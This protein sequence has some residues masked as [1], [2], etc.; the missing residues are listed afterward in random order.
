MSKCV[1]F[2]S[3]DPGAPELYWNNGG[4]Y[5][6]LEQLSG[7]YTPGG[8]NSTTWGKPSTA[9]LVP[10]QFRENY[11]SPSHE[12]IFFGQSFD[13]YGAAGSHYCF[14][15]EMADDVQDYGESDS[16]FVSISLRNRN[17]RN[18]YDDGR[19]IPEWPSN[20]SNGIGTSD[21]RQ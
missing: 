20:T 10:S 18:W 9:T 19:A 13:A 7:Y 15:N 5:G 14:Y 12:D 11:R 21:F 8:A 2:R 16:G 17:A 6:I 3:D 4:L 1:I